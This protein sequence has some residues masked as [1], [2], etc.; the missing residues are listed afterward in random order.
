MRRIKINTYL[1]FSQELNMKPY[2]AEYLAN[3][4]ELPDEPYKY[5]L[6]GVVVHSGTS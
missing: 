3:T 2:T 6:R 1:K 4:P 5:N